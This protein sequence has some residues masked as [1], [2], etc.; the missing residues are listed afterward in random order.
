MDTAVHSKPKLTPLT[1]TVQ[2]GA[3]D[4]HRA[5]PSPGHRYGPIKGAHTVTLCR[6]AGQTCRKHSKMWV[7]IA[8]HSLEGG[9]GGEEAAHAVQSHHEEVRDQQGGLG[10]QARQQGDGARGV[11]A[12]QLQV[13]KAGL[14]HLLMSC[15]TV[16]AEDLQLVMGEITYTPA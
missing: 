9:A 1:Q 2:E 7:Q 14:P 16:V 5:C 6:E 4:V 13:L 10:G 12:P 3:L 11:D 15:H 8:F